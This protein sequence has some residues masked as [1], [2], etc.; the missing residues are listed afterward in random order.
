MKR[1]NLHFRVQA[2]L[3]LMLLPFFLSAGKPLRIKKSDLRDKIEAAWVG[4]MIGNIYGLPHENKYVN[5]PGPE[6]W[7]YG[8]TKNLDKLQKYDGAF[9]DDDTDLEYMYL[10]QMMK[11][12]PEP[13]YAQ[14]RDAWMY[15]IRDRVWLANRGALGLMHYGYTPPFTG[16]KELNPHWYQI[17][18]QLINEIWAFTAPGMIKYAADKSEW[19]ARI[20][21]DDWGV[22]PTIHYGAMYAAAF[23]E[24]DIRK[25]IDIGLKS[26]PADGRY[27][28]TVKDMISLHA[29][30]PKDWKAA[31]QEMAQKYYIHEH[32][33]TKTIWNANLN[34]ACAILAMLYGEGDFQRTLDLSCAMG[35]DADNQAATVAGLMGVMYGMK[36]LPENLYLP[37]KGWTKPFNDKYIN[38]TR[39]DLPDTQI[40]VIIDN[41]LQ[42]TIDLIVSKGGK[43]TGKPGSEV[44]VINPDADFRAPME[45]YYGP[46]PV[47][48]AGKAVDFSFYTPANKIYNWSL[49]SGT[50]PAGLTFTNG[51]LTGTPV[52]AGDYSIVLQISDGKE[53]QAREFSL[54]VRGHN[55]ARLADTIY[56]NV[57]KLNEKVLD[58]CWYTFGKSL[59]AKEISVINDGKTSGPGSVFYSLAAKANIPKVD[60]YGY[61]WNEPQE[62]EMIVFNTGG[63]EEFGGWFTSLNVQYLN[64]AGRWVPVEKSIVNPPLPASDIVFIQPHYAE[65]VLRFDPVKTKGIRI[66]GDAM[67]QSHWNKYTKNVSAFTSITELSVYP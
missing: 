52:K 20:T 62:V 31:W 1:K 35:F 59:Y 28:A 50:L 38:I 5:A 15:H 63:M 34:G 60:Y 42:Q 56:S 53:K 57:R 54:L 4:Q 37:V 7:P 66:I 9:S 27:A 24:K 12:G 6:N 11:H 16:S 47:L 55:L 64:E 49:I 29:K 30:Y 8:Y 10:L 45:F 67:V 39:Y 40:S 19:A 32:D 21:S 44:I 41:T 26:L 46:D 51:R 3:L 43:V 61:G 18:P 22:E 65:Y 25:L 2:T 14:L 23:F 58:S 13:T 36:G 33:M 48:V 17:D